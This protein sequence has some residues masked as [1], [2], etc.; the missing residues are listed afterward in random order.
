MGCGSV[1]A[2]ERAGDRNNPKHRTQRKLAKKHMMVARRALA[3]KL[4]RACYYI[5]RDNVPFDEDKTFGGQ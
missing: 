4:A 1:V 3:H 5:L 2:Q